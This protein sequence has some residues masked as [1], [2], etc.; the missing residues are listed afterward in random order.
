ML[1]LVDNRQGESQSPLCLGRTKEWNLKSRNVVLKRGK[2]CKSEG[3]KLIK[4][5]MIKEVN[6][7]G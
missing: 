2:L 3:I 1:G 4:R 6:D 5:E 7:E